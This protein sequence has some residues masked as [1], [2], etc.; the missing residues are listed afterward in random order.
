MGKLTQKSKLQVPAHLDWWGSQGAW[1]LS[2][3]ALIRALTSVMTTPSSW[4]KRSQ[5]PHLLISSYLGLKSQQNNLGDSIQSITPGAVV[6]QPERW[7]AGEVVTIFLPK[8][9][10]RQETSSFYFEDM[11]WSCVYVTSPWQSL[12]GP[13]R[14]SPCPIS[15][16]WSHASLCSTID[17]EN[18][19]VMF[20]PSGVFPCPVTLRFH[21]KQQFPNFSVQAS[22]L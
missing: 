4:S 9:Q 14:S 12:Q 6:L 13:K 21:F 2:G 20:P 15:P 3:T 22:S 16:T 1:G 5:R 8:E 18:W 10:Q 17:L 19:C 11:S 7:A